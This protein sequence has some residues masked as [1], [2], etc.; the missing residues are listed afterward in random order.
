MNEKGIIVISFAQ[1]VPNANAIFTVDEYSYG[2][3]I[4]E[5]I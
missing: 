1:L 5:N 2:Q 4:G 3:V